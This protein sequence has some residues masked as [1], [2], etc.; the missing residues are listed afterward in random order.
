MKCQDFLRI[1]SSHGIIVIFFLPRNNLY[2]LCSPV[3]LIFL[4]LFHFLLFRAPPV[5]YG[6]SQARGRIRA[7]AA[8][9]CHSHSN[10]G[11][12]PC[13]GP[14]P[15]LAATPDPP[16]TEWGQDW[17]HILMDTSW[18]FPLHHNRNSQPVNFERMP[19]LSLLGR[20]ARVLSCH[21]NLSHPLLCIH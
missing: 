13:L 12:E 1:L 3:I 5:A 2:E 18:S 9:L 4:F 8:S 10:V 19:D 7:V 20:E 14:T 15:H 16:P 21:C 6:S 11:S 17:T